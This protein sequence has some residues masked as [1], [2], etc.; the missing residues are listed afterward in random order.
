V[1]AKSLVQK[2]PNAEP[3]GRLVALIDLGPD[4]MAKCGLMCVR[5]PKLPGF[6]A[7][8]K[9]LE[10][11]FAE[12][13]KFKLIVPEGESPAGFIEY[14]PG[15]YNWRA[16]DAPGYLV[17]HC[18]YVYPS[19]N[20]H[21]GFGTRLIQACLDDAKQQR[22]IGVAVLVSDGTWC[23]DR[24]LF[25]RLRFKSVAQADRFTL[26]VRELRSGQLPKFRDWQTP[27]ERSTGWQL[28]YADQC[29]WHAKA[30]KE[31]PEVAAEFG[32]KLKIN[33]LKTLSEAQ[34][35]AAVSGVFA[36]THDGCLLADHYVS[37]TRFRSILKARL[38][39]P[40]RKRT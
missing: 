9:W 25:E 37:P 5:N 39:P 36:L 23:A 33:A 19:R 12:G 18:L 29:P 31:L 40:V 28:R 22:R 35:S 13:L 17:I 2:A 27:L 26:M 7:K 20:Q 4:D 10:Q 38:H 11:R 8:Q 1:C 16:L 6:Q 15:E 30:V 24:R 3:G 14:I 32:V 21:R 34:N